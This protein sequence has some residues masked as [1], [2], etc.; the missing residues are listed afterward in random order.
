MLYGVMVI[1]TAFLKRV[2]R[3]TGNGGDCKQS[4][5]S[6]YMKKHTADEAYR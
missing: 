1:N 3:D 6:H 4:D 2:K 5:V